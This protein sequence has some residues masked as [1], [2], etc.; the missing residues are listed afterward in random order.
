MKRILVEAS[1]KDV[2]EYHLDKDVMKLSEIEK[3]IRGKILRESLKRSVELAEKS[4]LSKMT[5]DEINQ[6]ID[7]V[8]KGA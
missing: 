4:G 8:R 3:M 1:E 2:Q 6:I 7:E 5:D